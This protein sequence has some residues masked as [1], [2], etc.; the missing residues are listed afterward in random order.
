MDTFKILVTSQKGGVGKSTI[1]ANIAAY[2]ASVA[3]KRTMLIDFDH[4][5]TSSTWVRGVPVSGLQLKICD[6]LSVRDAGPAMLKVKQALRDANGQIDVVVSDLTWVDFFPPA[7]FF[8]Y[9]LVIVPSSISPVE[10]ASTMEFVGRF[11]SVFNSSYD[12]A[13]KLVLVPSRIVE[14]DEFEKVLDQGGF[15][16]KFSLTTPLPYSK[17]AQDSFGSSYLFSADDLSLQDAFIQVCRE[18]ESVMN[19][20]IASRGNRVSSLRS[21]QARGHF[22]GG[23]SVLDHFMTLRN[24]RS[25]PAPLYQVPLP[26]GPLPG[27][28]LE[29]IVAKSGVNAE[30]PI[31]PAKNKWF[32]FLQ[33]RR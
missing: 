32:G 1:A 18:I 5:G 13:P 30:A 4:Q 11:A 31:E 7:L 21:Y 22:T 28:P 12:K 16:V 26:S 29:R 8:D 2:F 20:V 33:R 9:D 15:P 3:G 23:A 10:L 14:G 25:A 27:G 6:V 19:A 17:Q 24:Q